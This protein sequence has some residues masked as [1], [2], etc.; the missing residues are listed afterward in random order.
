MRV[1]AGRKLKNFV[2]SICSGNLSIGGCVLLSDSSVRPREGET[3]Y[4]SIHSTRDTAKKPC[5]KMFLPLTKETRRI[6]L[7]DSWCRLEH[8]SVECCLKNFFD[9]A[10]LKATSMYSS[11]FPNEIILIGCLKMLS[12]LL[13]CLDVWTR[14][15]WVAFC[16]GWVLLL[17][18]IQ[19]NTILPVQ[20]KEQ[21]EKN[22]EKSSDP[23]R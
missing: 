4:I 11:V 23:K 12:A 21:L 10:V 15:N 14:T 3:E 2:I 20:R 22:P 13:N 17:R 8:S 1:C 7:P 5:A 18:I 9:F 6:Y 16:A 19:D